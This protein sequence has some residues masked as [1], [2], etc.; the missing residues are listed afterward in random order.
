[1]LHHSPTYTLPPF[2]AESMFFESK[3]LFQSLSLKHL[4]YCTKTRGRAQIMQKECLGWANTMIQKL[5]GGSML[6]Y[7]QIKTK[8]LQRKR[9]QNAHHE[10]F[11]HVCC[12]LLSILCFNKIKLVKNELAFYQ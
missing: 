8:I 1:M 9:I 4:D 7:S 3:T 10:G 2:S 12:P 5:S 11:C 6:I